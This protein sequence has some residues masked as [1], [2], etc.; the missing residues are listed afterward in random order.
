MLA[1]FGRLGLDAATVVTI[2]ALFGPAQ[3][4]ARLVE[5]ALIRNL[6]PLW[7]ARFAVGLLLVAFALLATFGLSVAIAAVF[8]IMFG[9]TNGLVTISRGTV[10]LALFGAAGYGGIVG[11]IASPSLIMQ[12]AAPLLLAF[13]IERASDRAALAVVAAFALVALLCFALVPRP[14]L[15]KPALNHDAAPFTQN[16]P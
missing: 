2:G 4:S 16:K 1:I 5:F 10:P 13:V 6:H 8:A 3:V 7:M 12:S 9:A 15:V 11:R 14:A